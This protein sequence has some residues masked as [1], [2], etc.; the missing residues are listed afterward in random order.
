MRASDS[1]HRPRSAPSR[2]M[3]MRSATR[4][5][6]FLACATPASKLTGIDA[7]A[8]SETVLS[9]VSAVVAAA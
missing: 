8:M 3:R 5:R 1:A 9:T 4:A 2:V 7:I 6:M